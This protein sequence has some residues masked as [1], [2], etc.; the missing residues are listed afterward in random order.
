M[1]A[2]RKKRQPFEWRKYVRTTLLL[3]RANRRK[4]VENVKQVAAGQARAAGRQ[5][6]DG[7]KAGAAKVGHGVSFTLGGLLEILARPSVAGPLALAGAIA[8][9][10]AGARWRTA[11]GGGETFVPLIVGM[12]LLTAALPALVSLRRLRLPR[13]GRRSALAAG[14]AVVLVTGLGWLGYGG[15]DVAR[16][17]KLPAVAGFSIWPQAAKPIEGRAQ[18]VGGDM[19]KVG[20]ATVRL[21][22]IEAPLADQRCAKGGKK[23][24]RCGEAARAALDRQVRGKRVACDAGKADGEGLVVTLCR[25]DGR[26]LAEELVRG[27]HVFA[28]G[29]FLSSYGRL[30]SAAREAKLG[31]WSGPAERPSE[32]RAKVAMNARR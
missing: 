29:S 7:A 20:T 24:W 8:L 19:L 11:S 3:R 30:E 12:T 15:A 26:D 13:I 31:I 4:K 22:G 32:L 14:A 21:A 10:S 18:V 9:A 1:F 16:R 25:V 28:T 27:G 17:V 23:T 2:R 6:R 5:A